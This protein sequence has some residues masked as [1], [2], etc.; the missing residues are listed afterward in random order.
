MRSIAGFSL[1]G[2][3]YVVF[4]SIALLWVRGVPETGLGS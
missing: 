1:V 2:I 4:G 3:P